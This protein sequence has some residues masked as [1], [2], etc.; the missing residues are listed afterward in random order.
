MDFLKSL[1]NLKY[2]QSNAIIDGI[3]AMSY[4]SLVENAMRFASYLNSRDYGNVI[5]KT[6]RSQNAIISAIGVMLSGGVFAFLSDN[7]PE[8]YL[9]SAKE[10]LGADL[11]VDDNINF[12]DFPMPDTDYKPVGKRYSDVV[13]AVFTSGSTGKPK[14]ALLTYKA[15]CETIRFQT[16]YMKLP[17][18]SHTGSYAQ[19]GFIASFWELWFPLANGFTLFLADKKTTHD[20]SL[21]IDF[22]DK[23]NLSYIFLPSSVAEIFTEIY[24]G[25]ALRFLRV[26]GGRLSS[27]GK[28]CG[29]EILYSLGMSEN[30]GS[31]TLLKIN[32]A[33]IS[34]IPLGKAF[35]DT[36]IYLIDGEIAVSGPKLFVGYAGQKALTDKFLVPN[37]NSHG[38]ENYAKMYL[39]GD[40]AELDANGNYIYKGRKDWILKIGDI[41]TN[42]LETE[43]IILENKDVKEAAVIPITRTGNDVFIACFFT[44]DISEEDLADYAKEKL[45]PTSIPSFF[46]KLNALPRTANGKIDRKLLKLPEMEKNPT[47]NTDMTETEGVIA[48]AFEEIL[49]LEKGFVSGTDSF[50][51]LGG[52][53]LGLMRLQALLYKKYSLDFFYS[54]LLAAQTPRN[55]SLLKTNIKTIAATEPKLNTPYPLTAPERQMWLLW[56]T[57]QDNGRYKVS[58]RCDFDGEIDKDKAEISLEKLIQKNPALSSVYAEEN[59]EISR[60]F[61]DEK[62]TFSDTEP[63]LF[64][65]KNGPIF[66]AKL[67]ENSIVFTAHHIIADAAAMRVMMEDFWAL[68]NGETTE[69]AAS[70][71]DIEIYES[72][73]DYS[74]DKAFWKSKLDNFKYIPLPDENEEYFSNEKSEEIKTRINETDIKSFTLFSI[75]TAA[76]AEHISKITQ[77]KKVCIGVPLSGR[78]LPETIRTIGMLVRT[79]PLYISV[80]D[81]FTETVKDVSDYLQNAI[82]HQNYP[83]ELMNENFG[84]R[85]DVMV[86]FIPL[87]RELPQN[88][89]DN[90]LSPRIIRGSYPALPVELVCDLREE[91]NGFSVV[92]IYEKS[93]SQTLENLELK[94]QI[95]DTEVLQ[96]AD[97]KSV[98]KAFLGR[99]EGNFYEIGGTSLKAIQIE[100]A[101]L[102][103]GH[104]ISAADILR[105]KDF[106]DIIKLITPA[107]EIDWEAE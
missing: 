45:I 49:S 48:S 69:S 17:D 70:L 54:D 102:M 23:N 24:K 9:Q 47:G 5:I 89:N 93:Q 87:A 40:L 28:P 90:G 106:T 22:I 10:D 80:S 33:K 83:F 2:C 84:V 14:G 38:R 11:V 55:T 16:E 107:S 100:E 92:F 35:D 62:I 27:C 39:S 79:I 1:I 99:D 58:I 82:I 85:Y 63:S 26:A 18:G 4:S 66:A 56:R 65:L 41:K 97:F 7:T 32:E 8:E 46:V 12:S 71:H 77:S 64:D 98:W 50:F 57:G 30:S 25:G 86:N 34:Q 31:V 3:K 81:D 29:Y 75:F 78:N 101:M 72:A 51:A 21:L 61:S 76:V 59:G 53:S 94:T 73:L 103:K 95:D 104:Y 91:E 15:L 19:F 88:F 67:Y 6:A 74:V 20:T 43:R 36:E 42:P 52:N 60:Y 13:C 105:Y 37:P 96:I 68:Y 44:G